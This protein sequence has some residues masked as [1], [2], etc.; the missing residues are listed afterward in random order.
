MR[1]CRAISYSGT[2]PGYLFYTP[3]PKEVILIEK[4]FV[5][6]DVAKN[7]LVAH[8]MDNNGDDV[9]HSFEVENNNPGCLKLIDFIA[10]HAND[11][12]I[13]IIQ[14]GMEATN[15]YWEHCYQLFQDSD[16]LNTNFKLLLYTINPKV[17]KNFKKAYNDLPKTDSVDAWVIADRLRF[18]RVK[19]SLVPEEVYRPLRQITRFRFKLGESVRAEKNR[20]LTLVFLKF[21]NYEDSSP[22]GIFSDAS[23]ALL[24]EFTL[25]EII[26][27]DIK[28]LATFLFKNSNNRLGGSSTI[29]DIIKTL[30]KAARN[31]YRLKPRMDQAISQTLAMTFDNIRFFE[32]QLKRAKKVITRELKAIPQTLDTVNGIGP[33]LTAGIISEIGDIDRFDNQA[34]LASYAGLTWTK[35]QS[36]S[37]EAEETSLTKKGNKYLRY[38]LVEAANS[39]RV[40]NEEYKQYYYRKFNESS[41]HKHKRAL[42]LTARKFV[43]LVFALLSKGEI[44]QPRR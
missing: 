34:S 2:K 7:S 26:T 6:V 16:K 4:L 19:N 38:Y 8:A 3:K 11:S 24:E 35:H 5:G 27:T 36:G 17:V 37:F 10:K 23:M 41:K 33:I 32:R 20:A 12:E 28:E 18:G 39:L 44:Y 1:G 43:R 40:H 9:F 25:E 29:D 30:K 14:L 13:D 22:F 15:I 31:S 42:V 21:S